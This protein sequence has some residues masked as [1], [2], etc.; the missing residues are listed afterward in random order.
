MTYLEENPQASEGII[1]SLQKQYELLNGQEEVPSD[2]EDWM[3]KL[4]SSSGNDR[5]YVTMTIE[6][7]IQTAEYKD[8]S[9]KDPSEDIDTYAYEFIYEDGE[10]RVHN[11]SGVFGS[12]GDDGVTLDVSSDV[13]TVE[14]GNVDS[15]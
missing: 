12:V 7:R 11:K 8:E 3:D 1:E 6:E 2:M 4:V 10:W 5:Y 9:E 13:M 14:G 15:D